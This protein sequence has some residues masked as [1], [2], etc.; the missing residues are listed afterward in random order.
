MKVQTNSLYG[1]FDFGSEVVSFPLPDCEM[2]HNPVT[3]TYGNPLDDGDQGED[4]EEDLEEDEDENEDDD[5]PDAGG[6]WVNG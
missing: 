2:G 6:D 5:D 1:M 4:L 3:S